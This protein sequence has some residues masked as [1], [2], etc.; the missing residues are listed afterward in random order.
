MSILF[1]SDLHL[2]E[3]QPQITEIFLRFLETT[4]REA[5][6]LYILG[7]FFEVWVGDDEKTALQVKIAEALSTLKDHHVPVYFMHGNR[8][9]LIGKRFARRANLRLLPDPS[10]IAPYGR[11]V[12]LVHGDAFCTD[13]LS[14]QRFRRKAR[15]PLYQKLFLMLPLFLRRRIAHSMRRAS[16]NYI[17]AAEHHIM[18][19]NQDKLLRLAKQHDCNLI[20]HGHTHRPAVH[21]KEGITRAVLS[22]WH[23]HG[24]YLMLSQNHQILMKHFS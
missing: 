10:V 11:N 24:H 23:D 2:S 3:T 14:Y 13:D 20:I 9:F 7:D 18:D 8:D 19:V 4:A 5:E 6:A 17:N 1:I 21:Q 15:N 12:L 16:T 22:D